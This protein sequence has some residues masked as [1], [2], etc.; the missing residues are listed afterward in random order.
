M[1][2]PIAAS[3]HISNTQ[4]VTICTPIYSPF[5]VYNFHFFEDFYITIMFL[6]RKEKKP[7]LEMGIFSLFESTSAW[8]INI[9]AYVL[10][11]NHYILKSDATMSWKG[12]A[13]K[14]ERNR[15]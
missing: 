3:W 13:R 7:V 10:L 6:E 2:S 5:S 9:Q 15:S 1:G 11:K 8:N 14:S 4:I 12:H